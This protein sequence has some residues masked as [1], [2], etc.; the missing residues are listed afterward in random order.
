M[1]HVLFGP[2]CGVSDRHLDPYFTSLLSRT[3]HVMYFSSLCSRSDTG[4]VLN[5]KSTKSILMRYMLEVILWVWHHLEHICREYSRIYPECVWLWDFE[6]KLYHYM[7]SMQCITT[8]TGSC[9]KCTFCSFLYLPTFMATGIAVLV[10]CYM[11]FRFI[12]MT[13]GVRYRKTALGE[14]YVTETS[15][16]FHMSLPLFLRQSLI[17][18]CRVATKY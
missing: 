16:T 8:P 9:W 3:S 11:K 18:K 17:R 14:P 10:T 15:S 4:G 2:F 6:S 12:T 7:Y 13:V 1:I 5:C